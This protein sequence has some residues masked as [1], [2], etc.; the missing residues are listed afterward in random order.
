VDD[1]AERIAAVV[2]AFELAELGG[3]RVGALSKGSLQRLA[4]AQAFLAG[5]RVMV[6]DEATDGLDPGWAARL[7]EMVGE[8][9]AED[10][11]RVLLFASHDLEEVERLT[12]RAV[13]LAEG[14]VRAELDLRPSGEPPRWVLELGAAEA[15]RAAGLFPGAAPRP[16]WPTLRERYAEA[17]AP[18]PGEAP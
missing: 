15:K 9:R 3:R 12:E 13:V 5:R 18:R 2:E 4:L 10:P 8:W 14:R 1:P 7:R 11:E 6:L 16:A 17:A